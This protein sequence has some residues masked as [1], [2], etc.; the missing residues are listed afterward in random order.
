M[1]KRLWLKITTLILI[2]I[3]TG[4][5]CIGVPMGLF[6]SLP[7]LTA[8]SAELNTTGSTVQTTEEATL[9]TTVETTIETT[10][11]TEPFVM[12]PITWKTLP[13][14]RALTCTKAFVYDCRQEAYLYLLGEPTERIY[15]ASITKL[16]SIH[17]AGQYLQPDWELAA[18]GILDRIP[19]D[20]SV[21]KLEK[22]DILTV[23]MLLEGMLLPSGNDA[24]YLIATEAGREIA[25][26][27]DLS[28]DEAIAAFVAEMNRQAQALGMTGTL[29]QNPDG[30]HDE[31]HYTNFNDLV[32][33]AK[34]ALENDIVK[35]Y[36]TVPK[37]TV[38]PVFGHEKEW[39]NTN[40]LVNPETTY[41][42]PYAIGLKTG[43]H[44]AAGS[45]LL[46]AFDIEGRIYIIGVF[47]SPEFEDKLDDTLQLLNDVVMTQ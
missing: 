42:C 28:V 23:D 10:E 22:G 45:C 35:K 1:Q 16:M 44:E 5:V 27:P 41:Y 43:Q 4:V 38:S 21:A 7:H 14:D 12:P 47:G 31:A 40:L 33:L 3:I 30:W 6:D 9:E 32:T 24:A 2:V 46:S 37:T 18:G 20:A 29:Y 36:G 17:V 39:I 34:L 13:D 11:A 26:N 15:P 19:E 25:K 8:T